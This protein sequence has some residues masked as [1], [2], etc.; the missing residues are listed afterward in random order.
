[1]TDEFDG[2]D[3]ASLA[4]VIARMERAETEE[5][6]TV[7]SYI[8]LPYESASFLIEQAQAFR[9]TRDPIAGAELMRFALSFIDSTEH[10]LMA[11]GILGNDDD[12]F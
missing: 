9:E 2:I 5:S 8:E 3:P 1:M 11:E 4:E 12:P 6:T 10:C 7:V